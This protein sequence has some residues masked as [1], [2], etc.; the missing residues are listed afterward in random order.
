MPFQ[1]GPGGELKDGSFSAVPITEGDGATS[2]V[3]SWSDLTEKVR[4]EGE[5]K[6]IKEN[7]EARIAA[8][9][10]KLEEARKEC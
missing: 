5:L 6:R 9:F 3:A 4:A 2:D 7:M 8:R 10:A 1:G